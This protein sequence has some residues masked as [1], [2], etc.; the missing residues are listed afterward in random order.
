MPVEKPRL[1]L[2]VTPLRFPGFPY[3][4][5]LPPPPSPEGIKTFFSALSSISSLLVLPLPF[6]GRKPHPELFA[7]PA[8]LARGS[9]RAAGRNGGALRAQNSLRWR[10][11]WWGRARGPCLP[12]AAGRLGWRLTPP[13][14][15][16]ARGKASNG[17][18]RAGGRLSGCAWLAF[19]TEVLCSS[20]F[21]RSCSALSEFVLSGGATGCRGTCACAVFA[22]AGWFCL[23]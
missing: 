4:L 9:L 11:R 12:A 6:M 13:C 19:A 17:K 10:R 23:F 16:A 1:L 8:I 22:Q 14:P 2:S 21:Q 3:P 15:P 7:S 20:L 18:V 5:P